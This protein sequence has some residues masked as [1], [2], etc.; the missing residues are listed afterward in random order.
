[1]KRASKPLNNINILYLPLVENILYSLVPS[2]DD[3]TSRRK[4]LALKRLLCFKLP[5][6]ASIS[7]DGS[8]VPAS[9]ASQDKSSDSI[10]NLVYDWRVFTLRVE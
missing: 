7:T 10:T 1:M 5:R 8:V 2:L 3:P 4:A 9:S 6:T